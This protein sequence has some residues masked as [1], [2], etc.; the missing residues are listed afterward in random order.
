LTPFLGGGITAFSENR[1]K[2]IPH[3]TGGIDID[4]LA[5]P[6]GTVP[7]NA[8]FVSNRQADVGVLSGIGYNY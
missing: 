8:D 5:N 7:V 4:L 1:T 3:I 2:I 6:T